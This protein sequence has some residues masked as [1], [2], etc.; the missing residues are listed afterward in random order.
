MANRLAEVK[1]TPRQKAGATLSRK[2]IKTGGKCR[3]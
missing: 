1:K 3:P 2:S